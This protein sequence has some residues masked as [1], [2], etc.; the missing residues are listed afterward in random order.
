MQPLSKTRAPSC[1]VTPDRQ[2]DSTRLPRSDTDVAGPNAAAP[3]RYDATTRQLSPKTR[4]PLPAPMPCARAQ[5]ERDAA[6]N[7]S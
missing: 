7:T 1:A 5:R 3:A 6:T 4:A 2:L